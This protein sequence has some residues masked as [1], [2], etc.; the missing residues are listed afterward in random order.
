[1]KRIEIDYANFA[2][3]IINKDIPSEAFPL[4]HVKHGS[5]VLELRGMGI[6]A[7]ILS[8]KCDVTLYEEDRV[9]LNRRKKVAPNST[10]KIVNTDP[11]RIKFSKESNLPKYDYVI[12][13]DVKDLDLAMA[14]ANVAVIDTTNKRVREIQTPVESKKENVGT[15][16]DAESFASIDQPESENDRDKK[17]TKKRSGSKKD[18]AV[19]DD[20][21]ETPD[22]SED[23]GN[24]DNPSVGSVE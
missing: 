23:N 8:S 19:H 15:T 24:A 10:V 12:L 4:K 9:H 11:A 2:S 21:S 17:P 22:G 16:I 5:T 14:V 18:I 7:E 6:C 20:S 3:M 13:N 1:M